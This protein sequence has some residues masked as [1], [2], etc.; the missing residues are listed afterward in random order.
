MFG[1]DAFA[2]V[3]K[4]ERGKLD[5]KSKKCIL[6]GYGER[7]KG[8]RLFDPEKE[9]V[10]Y[11]RDVIFNE[12]EKKQETTKVRAEEHQVIHFYDV[13]PEQSE[14]SPENHMDE[15]EVEP[16]TGQGA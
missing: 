13:E 1:C 12:E 5:P 14:E 6:L 15:A 10:I 16:E 4:D 9:K 2:H 3:S 11:S 7:R 8:Y